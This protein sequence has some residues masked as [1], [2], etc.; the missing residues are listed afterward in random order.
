[1]KL[2]YLLGFYRD[3]NFSQSLLQEEK[4]K[5]KKIQRSDYRKQQKTTLPTIKQRRKKKKGLGFLTIP[6]KTILRRPEDLQGWVQLNPNFQ[7]LAPIKSGIFYSKP[8]IQ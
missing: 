7:S 6:S 4:Q 1:M 2:E 8:T 5:K 3:I